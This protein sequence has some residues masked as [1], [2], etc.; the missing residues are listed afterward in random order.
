MTP[1]FTELVAA[2]RRYGSDTNYVIAGGGNTSYK[3]DGRM[4]VKASGTALGVIDEAGFVEM[5]LDA[6]RRLVGEDFGTDIVAREDRF[7]QAIYAARCQPE[8]GQRPSVECAVHALFPHPLVIHTHATFV[9]MVSCA[10]NGEALA[11]ELWGDKVV[12]VPYVD[13]GFVLSEIVQNKLNES[14]P[15]PDQPFAMVL[16]N[17]GLFV[18]GPTISSIDQ[19]TAEIVGAVQ[20]RVQEAFAAPEV[21]EDLLRAV[22]RQLTPALRGAMQPTF[23]T[24]VSS[25]VAVA[26]SNRAD[27]PALTAKGPLIPDQ[28]VYCKSFPLWLLAQTDPR[29]VQQAV[30]RHL[31]ETGF[32]PKVVLVPGV[33]LIAFGSDAKSARDTAAMYEDSIRV[34]L[35]AEQLGGVGPMTKRDREFIDSWEVEQYR[36]SVAAKGTAGRMAGKVVVITGGAQGFG[37]GIA[38][39]L[40][41]EGAHLVLA[42]LNENLAVQSAQGLP[43]TIGLPVNV[44]DA[45]SV[46]IL[47]ERTVAEFGGIDLFISNAGILKAGSVKTQSPE[48]FELVTRVNY[49][50]YFHCVQA[51]A[52]IMAAQNATHA[53]GWTDIVQINSKSGLQG[54]NRNGAYSGGK[55]GGIGLTQSFALELIEDRIKVNS[56]CPGNFFEGPLWSDPENGLFAQYLRTGKVPGAT[57][58]EDVKR[59]Y[60]S[61]VPMGRGCLPRDVAKAILYVV[62]QE[63]ETGQ[64]LPVTGG[65]IMLS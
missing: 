31:A 58:L 13:P 10:A 48:E 53:G 46:Q 11:R 42:D 27:A 6:L 51:V 36:R 25:P 52:P 32:L 49:Q 41:M 19:L 34:L 43:R 47:V 55:F 56:I 61:K 57:S 21:E 7:K 2:S 29:E 16:Q 50:G 64:A 4:W 24:V 40:S 5:D 63:Y 8:K 54:S 28:I 38:Q 60:E 30:Q 20:A 26:F 9:N 45:K 18:A 15:S 37:L 62:E 59:F 17:H 65:Q 14:N 33:G 3:Q 35:G 44:A 22:L 1:A 23:A 12:W 39:E